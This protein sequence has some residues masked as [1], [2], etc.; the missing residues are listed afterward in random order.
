MKAKLCVTVEASEVLTATAKRFGNG[1]HV[2]VPKGWAGRKVKV[3]LLAE[4]E[5]DTPEE[6]KRE[7][8][9]KEGEK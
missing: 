2:I 7:S 8:T 4:G 3:V 1:A 5:R 6:G 9:R